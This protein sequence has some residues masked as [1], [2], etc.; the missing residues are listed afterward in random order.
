MHAGSDRTGYIHD[1]LY[2][3]TNVQEAHALFVAAGGW[4]RLN[5]AVDAVLASVHGSG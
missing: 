3:Q 4:S 5:T 2:Y 1:M